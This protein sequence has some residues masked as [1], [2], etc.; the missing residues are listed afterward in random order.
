M[1]FN[2]L[3]M[4]PRQRGKFFCITNTVRDKAVQ[5]APVLTRRREITFFNAIIEDLLQPDTEETGEAVENEYI[6]KVLS[7]ASLRK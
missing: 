7:V 6:A 2:P 1:C 3:S 4:G 5:E